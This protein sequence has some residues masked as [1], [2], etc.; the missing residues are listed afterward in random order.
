[1]SGPRLLVIAGGPRSTAST[2]HRL[3]NYRPFLEGDGIDVT[4]VEYRGG[5]VASPLTALAHRMGFVSDLL[6][7]TRG[8]DVV[9]VQ[10]V[11]PPAFLFRRWKAMGARIVYDYDDALYA[12]AVTGEREG[13]WRRRK[14]RFETALA[15][16]DVVLAGSPPLATYARERAPRVEV[17]YPSLDRHRFPEAPVRPATSGGLRVGWV[18]NDQ[19]QVYLRA[20]APVLGPVLAQR[21]EVRLAVCSSVRPDLPGE[22]AS[23]VDFIPWSEEGELEAVRSFDLAISPLGDEEWSR[24]RGGR[25]SVLLSMAAGVPVVASPGGGVDELAGEDGGVCFADD[26]EAWQTCLGRLL[27]DADARTRMGAQARA[28][29]A[30]EIWADVQYPR[31]REILFGG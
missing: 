19:S 18:G 9:L 23:R 6:W 7:A 11:L 28:T 10:K 24:A 16:A 12:R 22:L 25:V 31:L 27:D 30:R 15:A 14:A 3:W 2:R 20:L 1:M 8:Q 4:W 17:M 5:R 13:V 29:I 26:P 21:P